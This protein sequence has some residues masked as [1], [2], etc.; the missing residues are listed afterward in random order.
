[1]FVLFGLAIPLL[2]GPALEQ[3]LAGALSPML[4]RPM[5]IFLQQDAAWRLAL[6]ARQRGRPARP[7]GGLSVL[8]YAQP[9]TTAAL[10]TAD[11]ADPG[12]EEASITLARGTTM[13]PEPLGSVARALRDQRLAIAGSEGWLMAGGTPA[14]T[15][16][17][18]ACA[19]GPS[20]TASRAAPAATPRYPRSALGYPPGPRRASRHPQG[21]AT[22]WAVPPAPGWP[23]TSRCAKVSHRTRRHV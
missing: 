3:T 1:M 5:R 18:S 8:L 7:I 20:D 22:Q 17:P 12:E 13:L 14:A 6:R 10:R 19:S 21:R 2:I 11:I 15:S 9:L 4:G 23:T 16:A